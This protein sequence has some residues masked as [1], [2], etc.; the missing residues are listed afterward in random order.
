[1]TRLHIFCSFYCT[2]IRRFQRRQSF[3]QFP[4]SR[5]GQLLSVS[6]LFFFFFSWRCS[7]HFCY[8]SNSR[9]LWCHHQ[10][11]MSRSHRFSSD[12]RSVH[13]TSSSSS[14]S[15]VFYCTRQENQL[16]I[17]TKQ[18][19]LLSVFWNFRLKFGWKQTKF[20]RARGESQ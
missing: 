20:H 11:V 1:M 6:A 2:K 14:S 17:F 5:G 12:C 19:F 3:P 18:H 16:L 7:V 13:V 15:C 4:F 8:A 10:D 9:K